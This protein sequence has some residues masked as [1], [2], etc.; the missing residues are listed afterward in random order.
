MSMDLVF[1]TSEPGWVA[2]LAE[3]YRAERNVQLIDD[4]NVGIS[5]ATRT[6][7]PVSMVE[8]IGRVIAEADGR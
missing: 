5:P 2:R 6:P 1:R 7:A 3:A 4:A 8:Q